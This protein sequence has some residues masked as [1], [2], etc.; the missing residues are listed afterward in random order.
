M[1]ILT[2]ISDQLH[3]VGMPELPEEVNLRLGQ[4]IFSQ[5]NK[6]DNYS[7]HVIHNRGGMGEGELESD[8]TFVNT[9]TN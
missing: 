6:R 5:F 3:Q 9:C 8:L 2:A 1:V 4:E 7:I